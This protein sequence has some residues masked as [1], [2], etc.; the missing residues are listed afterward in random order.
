MLNYALKLPFAQPYVFILL[1]N[2]DLYRT[3]LYGANLYI[4]DLPLSTHAYFIHDH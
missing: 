2:T 1:D 3:N 4:T